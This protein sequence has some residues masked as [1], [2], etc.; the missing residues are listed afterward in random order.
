MGAAS[1][2]SFRIFAKN[3]GCAKLIKQI[4]YNSNDQLS[5]YRDMCKIKIR[6]NIN[7]ITLR[8]FKYVSILFCYKK[9]GHP[10]PTKNFRIYY[11]SWLV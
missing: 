11:I 5:I 8:F 3:L 4:S 1:N 7:E 6:I 2:I 10:K 9:V